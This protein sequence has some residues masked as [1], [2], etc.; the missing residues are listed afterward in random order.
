M[1]TGDE[2]LDDPVAVEVADDVAVGWDVGFVWD[3]VE[4]VI[5]DTVSVGAEVSKIMPFRVPAGARA[6]SVRVCTFNVVGVGGLG[7]SSSDASGSAR[8]PLLEPVLTSLKATRAFSVVQETLFWL[9]KAMIVTGS[10]GTPKLLCALLN[11]RGRSLPM[12]AFLDEEPLLISVVVQ[13]ESP[14]S[15]HC[16]PVNPFEQTQE[17]TS[18]LETLTPPLAQ[19]VLLS[20]SESLFLFATRKTGTRAATRMIMMAKTQSRMKSQRGMPQQR[21]R[22]RFLPFSLPAASGTDSV[23]LI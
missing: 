18:P 2:E 21:R 11:K 19:G 7:C 17:Q 13:L 10:K 8:R 6:A 5:W 23:D 4:K 9:N 3:A 20:Q 15:M 22:G 16:E 14:E 12:V 1:E